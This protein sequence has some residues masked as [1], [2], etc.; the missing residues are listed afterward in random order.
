MLCLAVAIGLL[1]WLVVSCFLFCGGVVAGWL[2]FLVAAFS[3]AFYSFV[4]LLV[5]LFLLRCIGCLRCLAIW[6]LSAL[7]FW[8][9]IVVCDV[10]IGWFW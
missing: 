8:D 7:V 3:C 1:I 10:M 6:L 9:L 2:S 4:G 5:A